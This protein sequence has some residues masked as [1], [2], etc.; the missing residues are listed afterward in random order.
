M[1]KT[2]S[3]QVLSTFMRQL[4]VLMLLCIVMR[5]ALAAETAGVI[6]AFSGEVAIQRGE[7]KH[8]PAKH[9]E[10]FSGDTI[11]TGEGQV[12]IRFV[13]GTMLTLYRDTKFAVDDYHYGKGNG[14]RAQFSLLNGVMHT[15]TGEID[16]KNYL[17]KTRLANLGVRGTEYSV[18]L[19]NAMHVSVDQGRV[20]IVNAGG[21]VQI[22]AGQSAIVTGP[23]DM[24]KPSM[25]G[26]IDL[27]S[28][29]PG[30][31]MGRS[32]GPQPGPVHGGM[33]AGGMPSG[34][35]VS[36]GSAPPPPPPSGTQNLSHS[37]GGQQPGGGG[38]PPSGG[39]Q[40]PGGGQNPP[41]GP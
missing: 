20:E 33:Q 21:T 7:E 2:D 23:N 6:L 32:G 19:D 28:H 22:G 16:K 8:P 30:A 14:D 27:R 25:G 13:D 24:P 40:P 41:P 11:V 12:Q 35:G 15:L 9:A 36:G 18:Q 1:K 37:Q 3:M 10:L 4:L 5:P 31:G 34:G 38:L 17:L 26:K 39:G 29:G